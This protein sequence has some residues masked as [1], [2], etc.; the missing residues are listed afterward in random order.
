M[1][2]YKNKKIFNKKILQINNDEIL[3]SNHKKITITIRIIK[4]DQK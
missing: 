4:D 1:R 2:L 3:S